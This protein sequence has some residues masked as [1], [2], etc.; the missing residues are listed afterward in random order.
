M[1]GEKASSG[2][3]SKDWKNGSF[4][5]AK[6]NQEVKGKGCA[7]KGALQGQNDMGR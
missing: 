1:P 7:R 5:E 3:S 6:E 2:R 4:P